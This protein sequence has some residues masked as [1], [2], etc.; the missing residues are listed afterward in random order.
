MSDERCPTCGSP[1]KGTLVGKC[2]YLRGEDGLYG[3]PWH[4][5]GTPPQDG[6]LTAALLAA[7]AA[8]PQDGDEIETAFNAVR[9]VTGR[10]ANGWHDL[11]QEQYEAA[12]FGVAT[13]HRTMEGLREELR[14]ARL[15]ARENKW[16]A[17]R[18]DEDIARVT[19][20]LD[21]MESD[22]EDLR[23]ENMKHDREMRSIHSDMLALGRLV[24]VPYDGRKSPAGYLHADIMPAVA[25]LR[26]ATSRAE[27][28]EAERDR[29]VEAQ[30][31]LFTRVG[32][33]YEL[34]EAEGWD[35]LTLA[36]REDERLE[37][38]GY[39]PTKRRDIVA[40]RAALTPPQDTER[41]T[42]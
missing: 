6:D 3:D 20:N 36:A 19:R 14:V 39:P 27:Q 17:E 12:D 9:L 10:S 2:M 26:E 21:E 33:L 35:S 41:E 16:Y 23:S 22:Y 30:R 13:I 32:V 37:A 5:T 8:P 7:A 28:A 24:G 38:L 25:A 15:M 18:R 11:T 31:R 40:R 4:Q 42:P 29:A 1:G 34:W